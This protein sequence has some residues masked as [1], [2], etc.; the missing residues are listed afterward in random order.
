MKGSRRGKRGIPCLSKTEDFLLLRWLYAIGF[1]TQLNGETIHHQI[2]KN[3]S[4]DSTLKN[5]DI[6]KALLYHLPCNLAEEEIQT[7]KQQRCAISKKNSFD[8]TVDHFIP[9]NWGHGGNIKGNVYPLDQTLNRTKSS[10]NPFRWVKRTGVK[11]KINMR[12][13]DKLIE[14]LAAQNGLTVREFTQYVN[15]CEENKRDLDEVKSDPRWSIEIWRSSE[16]HTEHDR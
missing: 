4:G 9:I 15:W 11:D 14:D 12:L 1:P 13:W 7:L 5:K 6:R 3:K 2:S 10:L 16:K 8:V